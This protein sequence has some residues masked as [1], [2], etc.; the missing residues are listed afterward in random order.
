MLPCIGLILSNF[1]A[2]E[3]RR[4][5]QY[6]EI[7]HMQRDLCLGLVLLPVHEGIRGKC[8]LRVVD[9]IGRWGSR[10][11]GVYVINKGVD[12]CQSEEP[13]DLEGGA[14]ISASEMG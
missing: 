12:R 5:G 9:D 11:H 7:E 8:L 10:G 4:S 14:S 1:R 2:G 13:V 6:L 3:S